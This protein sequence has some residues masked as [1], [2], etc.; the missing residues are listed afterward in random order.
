MTLG[1]LALAVGVLV[2]EA[3]VEIENIHTRLLPGVSPRA[4]RGGGM[5]PDRHAAIAL[6]ALR[7]GRIC[8]VLLHGRRGSPAFCSAFAGRWIRDDRVVSALQQSGA[9]ILDM[10]VRES[11][12]RGG[13]GF[14]RKFRSVYERYLGAVLRL[15]W[16]LA[17]VYLL[18]AMAIL[19]VLF[20]EMGTEIF[21]ES[22]AG[23]F[24]LR[25]RAPTGTRVEETER[26]VLRALDVIRREAGAGNV[27]ITSDF[28][29]VVPSSYPVDLIHLFTSGPQ[30][31]IFQVAMKPGAP[32]GEGAAGTAARRTPQRTAGN[33]D[34]IRGGRHR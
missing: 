5:Q 17:L 13:S 3:T 10:A 16:P 23:L 14:I 1:G 24:R 29:G 21:P 2:D 11:P 22:N 31:A 4:R 7:P 25:L 30:E 15:R 26:I 34:F 8:S 9:G 28:V 27:E 33:S 18:A 12:P 32:A 19:Y 20:P 6:H